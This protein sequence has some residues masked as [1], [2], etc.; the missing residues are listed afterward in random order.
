[1]KKVVFFCFHLISSA[2]GKRGM[3]VVGSTLNGSLLLKLNQSKPLGIKGKVISIPRDEVI[4]RRL[5]FLENGRLRNVL[6]WQML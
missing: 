1:M 6:F 3:K 2:L 4:F 5:Q